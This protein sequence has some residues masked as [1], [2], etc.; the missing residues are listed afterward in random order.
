M[1]FE[2]DSIDFVERQKCS[3]CNN[4]L[5]AGKA[6]YLREIATGDL[7][8]SG[9][10]CAVKQAGEMTEKI[11]DFTK[12]AHLIID[13]L[14]DEDEDQ[15]NQAG[16]P[17]LSKRKQRPRR[18]NAPT[19]F[20]EHEYL[21]LRLTKLHGFK[22]V[23][24]PPLKEVFDRY[25]AG[26][27]NENDH[28]HISRLMDKM[29]AEQPALSQDNLQACY[30]FGYWI[31]QLIKD[32]PKENFPRAMKKSL[33]DNLYLSEAQLSGL[34]KWFE[35]VDGLPQLNISTFIEV[36]KKVKSQTVKN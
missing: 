17:S 15:P 31:D 4:T 7:K 3:F 9:P 14:P 34:N 27:A 32:R 2:Y 35:N 22:R 30:A 16:S 24:Y 10:I 25:E 20:T 18:L 19:G 28:S 12:C 6:V 33:Q 26:Q 5:T 11:P 29:A 13:S 23:F 36:E 8:P 21:R 1:D